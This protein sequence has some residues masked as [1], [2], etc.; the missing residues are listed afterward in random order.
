M[1][2]IRANLLQ[3]AEDGRQIC[4]TIEVP[5]PYDIH[6]AMAAAQGGMRMPRK[7]GADI[8][9]GNPVR[10]PMNKGRINP[11][12]SHQISAKPL[13]SGEG[14]GVR[15]SRQMCF[16]WC[17]ASGNEVWPG[18]TGK[19]VSV[20]KHNGGAGKQ[21]TRDERERRRRHYDRIVRGLLKESPYPQECPSLDFI[22][23]TDAGEKPDSGRRYTR[24]LV[25]WRSR[26]GRFGHPVAAGG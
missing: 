19:D 22:G 18:G 6:R 23:D 10:H 8:D 9:T 11:K 20:I 3:A 15:L 26:F 1:R 4:K 24:P 16:E 21:R 2:H 25:F 17:Q 12:P 7:V 14:D 13:S 5:C